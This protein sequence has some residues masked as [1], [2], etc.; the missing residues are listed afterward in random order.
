MSVHV[1]TTRFALI[2]CAVL[3]AVGTTIALFPEPPARALTPL[4]G[5]QVTG[6][7]GRVTGLAALPLQYKHLRRSVAE[8]PTGVVY[9]SWTPDRGVQPITVVSPPF[10][11]PRYLSVTIT[12]TT[13][14]LT[15][16]NAA[17]LSCSAHARRLPI[18]E[19][20]VNVGVDEALLALPKPWCSGDTR[21]HLQS[22]D[23]AQNVGIGT[24][25]EVSALSWWKSSFV[26]LVPYLVLALALPSAIA[27]AGTALALRWVPGLPIVPMAFSSIGGASLA[28]FYAYSFLSARWSWILLPLLGAALLAAGLVAG[29]ERLRVA[30][31]ELTP[32]AIAWA[33]AAVAYF[34][35]LSAATNG[36]AHWNPNY[37]FWPAAWSSD[38]ELPWLIAEAVR[39][40]QPL[41]GLFGAWKATDRPPLMA[42]T[43]LLV[44]DL[45]AVMQGENDG[46]YLKG[47][48]YNAAAVAY[49]AMWVPA[50]LFLLVSA[51]GVARAKATD[52]L[53]TVGALP[54]AVFNTIYG[55]PKSFG[56]ALS[57]A[58]TAVA[59]CAVGERDAA[60]I[61][62]A[63]V[64]FGGLAGLS[65]LAHGSAAIFL[66]PVAAWAFFRSV[67]TAP[68]AL[69][70][71]LTVAVLLLASWSVYRHVVL[72][73]HDPVTRYALVADF[74]FERPNQPLWRA[75][76]EKYG[77]F[78]LAQWLEVK[79]RMLLQPLLPVSAGGLHVWINRDFGQ[80]GFGWLR[81]RDAVLLSIGN[82][83][84][85]IAAAGAL[86]WLRRRPV[87]AGEHGPAASDISERA[88]QLVV[89][90]LVTWL[91][92]AA[93]FLAPLIL[94][95]WPFAAVFVMACAGFG[96]LRA[97]VPRAFRWLFASVALY[98]TIVWIIAPLRSATA[99]DPLALGIALGLWAWL[100]LGV[101][102]RVALAASPRGELERPSPA[103]LG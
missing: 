3:V 42:G 6:E 4:E 66:A 11:A 27:V 33:V 37:R 30:V 83:P 81:A 67:R 59:I 14:T 63:A 45:F 43:H 69:A 15:G 79:V 53:I 77:T 75:V 23:P 65:L 70:A 97:A 24:A 68:R 92:L 86:L 102:E 94:H 80:D 48:A 56:A 44:A 32:Y 47:L 78:T 22:A 8:S 88:G 52:V 85:L 2:A 19:G 71:G 62:M 98:T 60:R 49:G 58:A 54:F 5:W 99:I 29:R 57:I 103:H 50:A 36:L 76:V 72:P 61:R 35:L 51:V 1:P 21:L 41:Q 31:A 10:R 100:V 74:G 25:Y 87:D 18:F 34:A 26:G 73:T 64:L 91:I 39:V 12:G 7:A 96:V 84:I 28:M 82:A 46:S 101:F 38:N 40:D 13:R 55:W 9:R 16:A 20:S 93:V 90:C 89:L 95:V 17:F